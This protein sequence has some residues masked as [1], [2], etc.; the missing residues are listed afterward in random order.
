MSLSGIGGVIQITLVVFV[1]TQMRAQVPDTG[2]KKIAP[3]DSQP[4]LIDTLKKRSRQSD[5]LAV[6]YEARSRSRGA[7]QAVIDSAAA[8]RVQAE[9]D[10]RAWVR[11][12]TTFYPRAHVFA[13][14]NLQSVAGQSSNATTTTGSLGVS[15]EGTRFRVTGLVSVAAAVDTAQSQFGATMLTTASGST[16][17]AGLIDIRLWHVFKGR[18]EECFGDQGVD[19][20]RCNIGFRT[21][22]SAS[23]TF[24]RDTV[25]AKPDTLRPA[26]SVVTWAVYFGTFYAFSAGKI[27]TKDLSVVFNLGLETRVVR[28]DLLDKA[29][30]IEHADY[31]H[32][33][34]G[35]FYGRV[36]SL[37]ITYGDVHA[38]LEYH[39]LNG[40][41]N[42]FS[43]GAIVAGIA[44]QADLISGILRGARP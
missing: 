28:G 1:A 9:R 3:K 38:S 5:S 21:S 12:D 34:R 19:D 20:W 15:Y 16:L 33:T 22:G 11:A 10:Y 29:D 23:S 40:E 35:A 14:G 18:P 37:E 24:W 4:S 43:R 36:V 39:N 30:S 32:T 8:L 13:T 27:G 41:V 6:A 17:N 42:G 2:A 31:L 7:T 26:I 44:L 25:T